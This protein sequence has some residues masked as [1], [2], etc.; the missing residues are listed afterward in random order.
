MNPELR[1]GIGKRAGL[2]AG[3]IGMMCVLAE[4]CFL[5]PDLLVTKDALPV[6]KAHLALFRGILQA[7][8]F[9]AL[10]LGTLGVALSRPNRRGLLGCFQ[11]LHFCILH[12]TPFFHSPGCSSYPN[13]LQ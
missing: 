1:I 5:F 9:A 7:S 2:A 4:F 13:L 10:A 8:I 11:V 6:Y 12:N 3:L